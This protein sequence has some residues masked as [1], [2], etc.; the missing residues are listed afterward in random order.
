MALEMLVG[1][2]VV[3]ET[4]YQSY[5]EKMAPILKNYGGGFNCDFKIAEVV[6]APTESPINRVFT[7]FF[8]S[9]ESKAGFFSDEYYLEV[10]HEHLEKAVSSSTI[11]AVYQT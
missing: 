3:D 10:K 9:D 11:I 6:K 1:V 8:A 7:I 4:A 2:N 5:R